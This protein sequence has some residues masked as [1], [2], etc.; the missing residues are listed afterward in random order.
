MVEI[1]KTLSYSF[2]LISSLKTGEGEAYLEFYA[3]ELS[4][5]ISSLINTVRTN[6]LV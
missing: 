1:V 6:I 2:I 5:H 4:S 3:D